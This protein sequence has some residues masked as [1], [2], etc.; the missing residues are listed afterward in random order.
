MEPCSFLYQRV[1]GCFLTGRIL[2][3]VDGRGWLR[4]C[5]CSA[6]PGTATKLFILFQEVLEVPAT[7]SMSLLRHFAADRCHTM[8]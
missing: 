3:H 7:V 5:G 2:N 1:L 6:S 8:P 4:I